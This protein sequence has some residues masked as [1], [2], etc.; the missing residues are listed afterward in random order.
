MGR[1][2]RD[3][4][5]TIRTGAERDALAIENH[6]LVVIY[7]SRYSRYQVLSFEDLIQEGWI[8]LMRASE[9][10]DASKGFTFAT[11]AVRWIR[12]CMR[13]AIVRF[14]RQLQATVE[15]DMRDDEGWSPLAVAR[16]DEAS[17][18]PMDALEQRESVAH[19]MERSLTLRQ[20]QVITARF[21][22]DTEPPMTRRAIAS[23]LGVSQQR[24][25]SIEAAALDRLNLVRRG[26]RVKLQ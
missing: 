26:F 22:L 7:A 13:R 6:G 2:C 21:G 3:H 17:S 5:F 23:R 19:L 1:R 11:Y 25:A 18:R 15:A 20:R 10:Y 14:R 16:S 4:K 8:G 24:I 9:L 12:C